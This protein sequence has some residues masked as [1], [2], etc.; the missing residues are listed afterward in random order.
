MTFGA[1]S[2]DFP[3]GPTSSNDL[4]LSTECTNNQVEMQNGMVI[5]VISENLGLPIGI[6]NTRSR[7]L[8]EMPMT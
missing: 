7:I 2:R 4:C 8:D 6:G 1:K 5:L 3:K